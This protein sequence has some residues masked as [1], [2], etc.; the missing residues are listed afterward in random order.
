MNGPRTYFASTPNGLGDAR[1][2]KSVDWVCVEDIVI[3]AEDARPIG[4]L[5]LWRMM[6]GR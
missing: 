4:E 3:R 5:D 2:G 6:H 1:A